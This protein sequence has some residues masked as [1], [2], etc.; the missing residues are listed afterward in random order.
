MEIIQ[1]IR[2]SLINLS[3]EYDYLVIKVMKNLIN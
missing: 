1:D 3:R 2:V